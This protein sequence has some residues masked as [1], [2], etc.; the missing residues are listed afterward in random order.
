MKLSIFTTVTDPIRR[1][2]PFME[3]MRCYADIADEIV[4][5][6]GDQIHEPKIGSDDFILSEESYN[7]P[8][9][10]IKLTEMVEVAKKVKIVNHVWPNNFSWPFIGQ[11]F[12]RGYEACT[13]DWV[14]RMDLDYFI[15]ELSIKRLYDLLE[16]SPDQMAFSFFKYQFLLVDRYNLKSRSVLAVNKKKYGNDIRF[17]SGGDLCQPSYKGKELTPDSVPE[18]R[19][20]FWN[21]D[22]CFKEKE[23]I[24]RDWKRFRRAW[25]AHFHKDLRTFRSFMRGKFQNRSWQKVPLIAHPKYITDKVANIT[26]E[27]FGYNMFGLTKERAYA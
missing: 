5:V 26:P 12:Q 14:I 17:D 8:E 20:P 9:Y 7:I 3:A 15:H 6:V 25:Q 27:Q 11:Q 18:A 2:D 10:L 1:Q 22:F 16:N 4:V 24:E 23:T 19:V 21:Y 13:G